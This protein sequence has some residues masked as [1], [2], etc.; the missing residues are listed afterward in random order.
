MIQGLRIVCREGSEPGQE[1]IDAAHRVVA[2]FG[3]RFQGV[4]P[5]V[6]VVTGCLVE[7]HAH[8][9]LAVVDPA[10]GDYR[11]ATLPCPWPTRTA[12]ATDLRHD[13]DDVYW[14]AE[15]AVTLSD[16]TTVLKISYD[17][18]YTGLS[19]GSW[20]GS[21]HILFLDTE[22][23]YD[24][25]V[26]YPFDELPA[27]VVSTPADI[28]YLRDNEPE[29][30]A[31]R[32]A[33][34]PKRAAWSV[35]RTADTVAAQF[36]SDGLWPSWDLALK[37]HHPVSARLIRSFL[38]NDE[39]LTEQVTDTWTV[40]E[41]SSPHFPDLE[42][43][44]VWRR[45]Y[46]LHFKL[47][48][49]NGEVT[50]LS[51]IG[52]GT[53][54]QTVTNLGQFFVS[55]FDYDN[56]YLPFGADVG[57]Y[58]P[59]RLATYVWDDPEDPGG[60]PYLPE[61][62]DRYANSTPSFA[63]TPEIPNT[64]GTLWNGRIT[65]GPFISADAF[66][67]ALFDNHIVLSGEVM[68][69]AW[70]GPWAD[71]YA[72]ENSLSWSLPDVVKEYHHLLAV[73]GSPTQ[74]PL[75]ESESLFSAPRSARFVD[76]ILFSQFFNGQDLGMY[77]QFS[78]YVDYAVDGAGQLALRIDGV[79]VEGVLRLRWD[80]SLLRFVPSGNVAVP[81]SPIVITFPQPMPRISSNAILRFSGLKYRD[82]K[83]DAKLLRE[84]LKE[85]PPA[86]THQVSQALGGQWTGT[87]GQDTTQAIV[88]AI[89]SE[90]HDL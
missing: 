61:V 48:S 12:Y 58:T 87:N 73:Q 22:F 38:P 14:P 50:E 8:K 46:S 71:H 79:K 72:S 26:V 4:I 35:G 7:Y 54:T 80:D 62:S 29:G 89:L 88:A 52:Q 51:T 43:T 85:D 41:D 5:V 31:Y 77:W 42:T 75:G 30:Q 82:M 20:V 18:R 84:Y 21:P 1:E 37:M 69:A 74:Q 55:T 68:L 23:P 33:M 81:A 60:G 28:R 40:Q 27:D 65:R 57:S 11:L 63:G 39:P 67:E 9:N 64:K 86:H 70:G 3:P 25:N 76:V 16:A 34:L 90:L 56:F 78:W 83:Q 53:L 6:D 45:D 66:D 24:S 49:T 2:T 19:V 10:G 32:S 13:F 47:E 59:N 15:Y 44:N 17:P 36:A